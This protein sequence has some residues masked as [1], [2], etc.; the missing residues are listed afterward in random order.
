[1]KK[2]Y[3]TLELKLIFLKEDMVRTSSE[4]EVDCENFYNDGWKEN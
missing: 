3:A 1:M 2:Q 4:I